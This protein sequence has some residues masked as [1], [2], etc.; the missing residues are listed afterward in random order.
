MRSDF[1]QK[2]LK[3]KNDTNYRVSLIQLYIMSLYFS[4]NRSGK[5]LKN[6][7]QFEKSAVNVRYVMNR[8][9]L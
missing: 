3:N 8:V 4:E 1:D 7:S 5:Y 2:L 6:D 9:A